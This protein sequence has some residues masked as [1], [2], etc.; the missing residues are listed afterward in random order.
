MLN[1]LSEILKKYNLSQKE[2]AQKAGVSEAAISLAKSGK[3][4]IP[5]KVIKFLEENYGINR[6]LLE[7]AQEAF[8]EEV[9]KKRGIKEKNQ[10]IE[11]I[12]TSLKN[13]EKEKILS[14]LKEFLEMLS[15]KELMNFLSLF[16]REK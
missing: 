4:K 13:M 16:L 3:T 15:E 11:E 6:K 14:I 1:P 10:I 9:K 12:V 5:K 8:I 7:R 2:L